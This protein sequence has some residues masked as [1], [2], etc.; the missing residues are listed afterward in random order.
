MQTVIDTF[1][2]QLQKQQLPMV[3]FQRIWVETMEVLL[4]TEMAAMQQY[5]EAWFALSRSCLHSGDESNPMDMGKQCADVFCELNKLMLEHA[6]KRQQMTQDWRER[7]TQ[8]L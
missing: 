4:E 7:M 3:E 2:E 1:R 5:M 8:I 6:H